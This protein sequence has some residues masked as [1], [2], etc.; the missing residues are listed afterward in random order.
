[1]SIQWRTRRFQYLQR[2]APAINPGFCGLFVPTQAEVEIGFCGMIFAYRRELHDR[3]FEVI[4]L[5][6]K[7][8]YT[9]IV[10][11]NAVST[12]PRDATIEPTD[13][14]IDQECHGERRRCLVFFVYNFTDEANSSTC[15]SN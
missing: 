3:P 15:R 12:Q 10:G 11:V 14:E 8:D 7:L 4:A 1:M 6:G 5:R 13:F 9:H 2:R